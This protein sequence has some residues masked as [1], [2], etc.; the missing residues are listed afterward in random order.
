MTL[1]EV[2]LLAPAGTWES[3]R[4]AVANGADAVYFGVQQFNARMRAGNFALEEIAG[5]MHYLHERGVRGYVALNVLMLPMEMLSAAVC[6]DAFDVAD[7]DGVIVQDMGLA[8]LIA[9][10]K[11]AGRWR[12][13]LHIS[14]QMTV[15]CPE[16]VRLVDE[17]YEPE[18]IVLAR[19][20]SI[21][22]I[23]ACAAASNARIEVFCHGALCVSYSGQCL[24]SESLGQRSANRGE[25]AQACRMPYRL[26]VDGKMLDLGERR[27]LFSPQDL[28]AIELLPQLLAA[29]VKC[30]KIE[31]RQKSPQYVAAVVRSY[32]RAL[33]AALRCQSFQPS[34]REMYAMQMV[35]SRGFST[36]W[37]EGTNH[38]RLT[39]GRFG[40]KRG[41]L[42]G[43]VKSCSRGCIVLAQPPLVP[44]T[45]GDGFVVDNGADRNA[46]QGGRIVA[47]EQC[48][49]YFHKKSSDI[50]WSCVQPGQL[51]W[52]TS[53]PALERELRATWT[54]LRPPFHSAHTQLHIHAMGKV[55]S[56]LTLS[57]AGVSVQSSIPL[58]TAQKHSLTPSTLRTQLG[59]LGGS[60][61]VL[62]TLRFEVAP[63]CMLPLSELNRMRRVLVERLDA[64]PH[65]FAR[66]HLQLAEPHFKTPPTTTTCELSLLARTAEQ[67]LSAA[68]TGVSRLYLD[69]PRPQ[70]LGPLAEQLRSLYPHIELWP[71]TMRIMKPHEAGYFKYIRAI[72]PAG[73]LVRNLGAAEYWK[74]EGLPLIG[75]FSLNVTNAHSLRLWLDWGMRA[76]TVS[77]DLN[78]RQLLQLLEGG[79]GPHLELVLHQHMPLFHSQ[80]CVF[81]TFLSQGHNFK[82]CGQPCKQHRVRVL[83]RAGAEHYL[84][85]DVGC[86][87]TLFNARAQTAAR[88]LESA[89]RC[90][91]RMLRIE[92]LDEDAADTRTLIH[93]YRQYLQHKLSLSSILTQLGALDRPGITEV[94][95]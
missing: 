91:L 42:V 50:D 38:P 18:Q 34:S 8:A 60:S 88:C 52:K 46:E 93:T 45:P 29:G 27:Y 84:L 72:E 32:R 7:V 61:Y 70:D 90:G 9:E 48:S 95:S 22:E 51:V 41:V 33:D 79:A 62:G 11:R 5:V 43:R 82:D 76:C 59:R 89:M 14:T 78:A 94:P 4:A 15:S 35:F 56:P 25:C 86:R 10:Q 20:L 40:K 63:G 68:S 37:L 81:C 44:V 6:L 23:A 36:G 39:H 73:V 16:A 58:A 65:A 57:C 21:N 17:L 19:E 55:G 85:S 69:L 64:S 1:G 67:A 24:T 87:N 54:Q 49:L 47:A 2:E 53:D 80:H 30:F 12:F 92:C 13:Q 66:P 31:G 77:Y 28:C 26:R 75:D 71:A 3:L 74:G 83:D